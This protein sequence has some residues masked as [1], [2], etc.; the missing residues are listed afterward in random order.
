MF[1]GAK[2]LSRQPQA[3]EGGGGSVLFPGAVQCPACDRRWGRLAKAAWRGGGRAGNGPRSSGMDEPDE[4][5]WR[6]RGALRGREDR[7]G[8][9]RHGRH[10]P[11]GP[12]VPVQ[13]NSLEVQ[14]RLRGCPSSGGPCGLVSARL[15]S[16]Q[17]GRTHALGEQ[18]SALVSVSGKW[19]SRRTGVAHS[20]SAGR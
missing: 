9:S 7:A 14:S 4:P 15:R 6:P 13:S 19:G 8:C 3:L 12:R 18:L 2:G 10:Q 17:E 20:G 5:G 11:R 16:H 1:P